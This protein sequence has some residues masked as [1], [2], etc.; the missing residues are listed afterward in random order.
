M[1]DIGSL[2]EVF[3][4]LEEAAQ[5]LNPGGD[6]QDQF[7]D[8]EMLAIQILDSEHEQF[9]PGLLEEYL[10]TCLYKKNLELGLI[11]NFNLN[12]NAE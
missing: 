2:A 5:R 11:P 6:P 12:T 10:N 3:A 1:S 4:R 7:D 8:Y 9:P